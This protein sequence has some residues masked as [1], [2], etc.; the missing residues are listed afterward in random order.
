MKSTILLALIVLL[1]GL[2]GILFGDTI[3]A[4]LGWVEASEGGSD[5]APVAEPTP[6]EPTDAVREGN[7]TAYGAIWEVAADGSVRDG[8]TGYVH[9]A[10]PALDA[11]PDATAKLLVGS[12][13][14]DLLLSTV[15]ANLTLLV[16]I[17]PEARWGHARDLFVLAMHTTRLFDARV[18]VGEELLTEGPADARPTARTRGTQPG[19]VTIHLWQEFDG[20]TKVGLRRDG[21]RESLHVDDTEEASAALAD[22]LTRFL[23]DTVAD[24][25][26]VLRGPKGSDVPMRRVQELV[27]LVR[28]RT[29]MSVSFECDPSDAVRGYLR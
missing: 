23:D 6:D 5:Q 4:R 8:R 7:T 24:V 14:D 1:A 22:V 16:R 25:T 20:T 10:A 19:L 3:A 17:H 11:D 2:V 18:M 29:K 9:I 21:A 12:W 15:T 26:I 13:E 27:G 28:A